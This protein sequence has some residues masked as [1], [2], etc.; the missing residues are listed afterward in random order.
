MITAEA[1]PAVTLQERNDM[2][3]PE[4]LRFDPSGGV[5]NNPD[6]P[7]L[8]Y[9]AVLSAE[10]STFEALIDRNG[11]ECRWRNGIFDYH[12]FHSTAHETLAV[13]RGSA[14]VLLGGEGGEEIDLAPGD[15]VI[16]PAGTGHKRIMSSPDL[17]IVGAYPPGQDYEIEKPEAGAFDEAVTRIK[18]VPLPASDPV[19]G[20]EGALTRLWTK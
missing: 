10:P 2:P 4:A 11:W 18:T 6:L 14:T 20:P 5:P 16:L 8:L 13:V 19:T 15:I 1:F 9:R 17:L 12:H 3:E 7:V